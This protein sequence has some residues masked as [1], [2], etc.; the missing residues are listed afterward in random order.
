MTNQC[1]YCEQVFSSKE[2]LFDHL[3]VHSNVIEEDHKQ[4]RKRK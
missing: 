1:Y 4:K 3:E 2:K